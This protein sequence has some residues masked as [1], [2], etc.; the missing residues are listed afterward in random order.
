MDLS[1]TDTWL[2]VLWSASSEWSERMYE[3]NV[4]SCAKSDS[5]CRPIIKT[6][7]ST[8]NS[9]STAAP[10]T[11]EA[12]YFDL[13]FIVFACQSL[14]IC[15]HSYKLDSVAGLAVS[16]PII[17]IKRHLFIFPPLKE[18]S[19]AISQKHRFEIILSLPEH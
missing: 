13:M 19:A 11:L 6:D 7:K 10:F 8:A 17:V 12:L 1:D 5:L 3:D 16:T 18:M 9:P 2:S 15:I 14:S 4:F